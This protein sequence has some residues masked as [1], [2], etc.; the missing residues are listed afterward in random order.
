MTVALRAGDR[1]IGPGHPCY[2]IAEAG[3]N[4]N[5]DVDLALRLVDAAVA[6]GADAV[7]FQTW[8]TERVIARDAPKAAYQIAATGGDEGQFAMVKRLELPFE[9]FARIAEHARS[10]GITF[11]STPFDVE[12]LAFL[13]SLGMPLIKVPSGEIDNPLLLRPVGRTGLPVILS[14]GMATLSDVDDAIGTLRAAGTREIA[15]L[16]CTS[17]YPADAA[18]ANLRAIPSLHATFGLPTG[19]SD[20]TLGISTALAAV[21]LGACVVEKHFTL[22][23][24][25]PGPD[26]AASLTPEELGTMVREIRAVQSALGDGV[27][28]PRAAE[29]NT[30]SVARRSLY[31][32]RDIAA[33][34]RID[35]EALLGMRPAG[36][37][38]TRHVDLFIGRAATRDLA[39][40]TMLT[41]DDV[42]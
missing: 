26:H 37:V 22:D 10:A 21:A 9:A 7:K 23:R 27:K 18:D 39:A 19:Y 33:G 25:L 8:V 40:G 5:G 28:A 41:W 34:E 32:A 13:S 12:S 11:L 14:T 16:Q 2:V 42:R 31:A 24:A 3:V 6:A 15:V 30:R 1:L 17:N 36:G 38:S 35:A 4:H 20:H 29:A